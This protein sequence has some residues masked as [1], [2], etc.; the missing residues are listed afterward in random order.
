MK[1]TETNYTDNTVHND[2][3][4]AIIRSDGHKEWWLNKRLHRENGP[5]VEFTNGDKEWFINGELHR[6]DG[7]AIEYVSGIKQWYRNGQRHRED[8]PAIET[9]GGSRYWYENGK[10]HREDGPAVE[11]SHGFKIW[12][13]R[14]IEL[15]QHEH[16]QIINK[17]ITLQQIENEENI[18]RRRLFTETYG[19]ER[20]IQD[21]KAKIISQDEYRSLYKKDQINDEPIVMVKVKNSTPEHDGTYKFY[22]M[23]VP[24]NMKTP[25]EAIAWTFGLNKEEY[26]PNIET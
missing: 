5:A 15:T 18:E 7:P 2:D 3:G 22:F 14:G 1:K 10:C 17:T 21:S 16:Q 23:R 20:Y 24:P 19:L 13:I 12:F 4:F 11:L 6:D 8:G 9:I 25:K 26:N